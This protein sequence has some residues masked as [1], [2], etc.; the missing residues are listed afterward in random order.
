MR[1]PV[2]AMRA[3]A[4]RPM[5]ASRPARRAEIR[6][7]AARPPKRPRKASGGDGDGDGRSDG[8]RDGRGRDPAADRRPACALWTNMPPPTMQEIAEAYEACHRLTGVQRDA[9]YIVHN[10]D[11]R[12]VERHYESL[13]FLERAIAARPMLTRRDLERASARRPPPADAPGAP[14]APDDA[15]ADPDDTT[16]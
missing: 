10:L 4:S 9:C 3:A 12:A 2:P 16:E 14:D 15:D 5:R 7:A 6:A 13:K 1:T 11:G 8:R